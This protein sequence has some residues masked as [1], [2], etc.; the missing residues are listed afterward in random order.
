MKKGIGNR[1]LLPYLNSSA[2]GVYLKISLV[3]ED[4]MAIEQLPF[5]FRVL[6]DSDPLTR[7]VGARFLTKAGFEVKKVFLLI[8]KD[9]CTLAKD[10]LWPLHNKQVEASWQKAFSFYSREAYE[11]SLIV[12]GNQLNHK[13][14]LVPLGSLFF[15]KAKQTFF[16]PPCPY[17]G[18][19]LEQCY[20]DDLLG[21]LG[22]S[23]YST[24]LSRYLFCPSCWSSERQHHFY[25]FELEGVET[26]LVK[27]WRGLVEDF[28]RLIETGASCEGF[29]CGECS[30]HDACYGTRKNATSKIVPF[31]FYPFF[32]LIFEDMNLNALDFLPLISGASLED[33]KDWVSERG[34]FGRLKSVQSAADKLSGKTFFF[35]EG[36]EQHFPEILYLKLTFLAQLVQLTLVDPERPTHPNLRPT[37][38]RTWVKFGD[39]ASLMPQFWNFKVRVIDIV[40]NF[41]EAASPATTPS[42][43]VIHFLGLA[44]FCT[45]LANKKQDTSSIYQ[46]LKRASERTPQGEPLSSTGVCNETFRPENL[47]WNPEGKPIEESWRPFWEEALLLG[48]GLLRTGLGIGSSG[49]SKEI[50]WKR[51]EA[52]RDR[53]KHQLFTDQAR[54]RELRRP[55]ED[56]VLHTILKNLMEK[57]EKGLQTDDTALQEAVV[58]T[59]KSPRD[60]RGIPDVEKEAALKETVISSSERG[61]AERV[62][63]SGESEQVDLKETV[64][65][66][67]GSGKEGGPLLSHERDEGALPETVI[68]SAEK[69]PSRP[70]REPSQGFLPGEGKQSPREK[71]SS[72]LETA[73]EE[74][75]QRKQ[76]KREDFLVETV[77]ISPRERKDNGRDKKE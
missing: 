40:R 54:T 8:Q 42:A 75:S 72:K 26:D 67:P 24:S 76:E 16:G 58:T 46:S 13:G 38:D 18:R 50:F 57:W 14:E 65:I 19:P 9:K 56:E 60:D 12:L 20:N 28:A 31:S 27:D 68:L 53:I 7:I 37:L 22:L 5:P 35:F 70:G 43:D 30:N 15:C 73:D 41:P 21:Q 34:E 66:S 11:D 55:R 44:W 49:W 59:P 45:L 39:Q 2:T 1:S 29:P 51:L 52:L 61:A 47:F 10:S 63:I 69:Q 74:K 71:E 62:A 3:T 4:A 64:V 23:V 32:M 48:D 36:G 6:N 77:F 33:L 25:T 17:C